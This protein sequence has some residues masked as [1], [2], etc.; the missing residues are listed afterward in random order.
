MPLTGTYT[1][2]IDDKQR[3]AVPKPLREA[4]GKD[5]AT[6]EATVEAS[7]LY[8]AP[9]T[10]TSLMVF[11][12]AGFQRY[13]DRF[14]QASVNR[15]DIRRYLRMF[16]AQAERIELDSQGRVRIPERLMQFAGLSKEAVILGVHD[17]AEVWD[18]QKWDEFLTANGDD[19]D[20]MAAQSFE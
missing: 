14:S 20:Q 18:K 7:V 15:T 13:S 17:H 4:F 16:Y 8:V 6:A 11:S 19:F 5:A 3:L 1:R 10:D 2:T 12:E 9:G